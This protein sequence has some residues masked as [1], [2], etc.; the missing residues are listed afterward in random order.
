MNEYV[1][2]CGRVCKSPQGLGYHRKYCKNNSKL[3]LKICPV[4]GKDTTNPKYCSRECYSK[5]LIGSK[6][7]RK[8]KGVIVHLSSGNKRPS[9]S[10]YKKKNKE[11]ME[12]VPFEEWSYR[13]IKDFLFKKHNNTCERCGF[14]Y[15]DPKTGKGPFQVHHKDGDN[16]NNKKENLEFLCLNCH[17]RTPNF[18]FRNRKHTKETKKLISKKSKENYNFISIQERYKKYI[19]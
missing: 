19:K 6:I 5:D 8:R 17:W 4:C 16:K 13:L 11:I 7:S 3:R 10:Y 1:C 14:Y 12:K 9:Y 15:R 18:A 2:E